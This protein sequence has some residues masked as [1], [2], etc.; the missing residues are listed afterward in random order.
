MQFFVFDNVYKWKWYFIYI[1]A[2]LTMSVLVF[3][4]TLIY[5]NVVYPIREITDTITNANN[6]KKNYYTQE[7]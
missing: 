1:T 7:Y 2:F 4:L 3:T 5:I 6:P